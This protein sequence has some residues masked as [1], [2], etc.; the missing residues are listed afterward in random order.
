[1]AHKPTIQRSRTAVASANAVFAC[2]GLV[3]ATGEPSAV[4]AIGQKRT[5]R[6]YL[7][8][9]LASAVDRRGA[10]RTPLPFSPRCAAAVTA[11]QRSRRPIRVLPSAVPPGGAP[12]GGDANLKFDGSARPFDWCPGVFRN[13]RHV[14]VMVCYQRGA[15]NSSTGSQ[16][17]EHRRH[18][19][20]GASCNDTGPCRLPPGIP[21]C[22]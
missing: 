9:P 5:Y 20:A 8:P 12:S 17:P 22:H 2:S 7:P 4:A 16:E 10:G 15:S 19:A 6:S 1:M 13:G 3:L 21:Y 11:G 18:R 14:A